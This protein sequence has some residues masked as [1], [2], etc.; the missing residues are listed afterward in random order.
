[1]HGCSSGL[2]TQIQSPPPPPKCS[3]THGMATRI[4]QGMSTTLSNSSLCLSLF[5]Q[6]STAVL[7]CTC[8]DRLGESH[9]KFELTRNI[10]SLH[11]RH[12]HLASGD[13]ALREQKSRLTQLKIH[14]ST[15]IWKVEMHRRGHVCCH[16]SRTCDVLLYGAFICLKVTLPP[17]SFLHKLFNTEWTQW[18][19]LYSIILPL[20][21]QYS[22]SSITIITTM[23]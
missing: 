13:F 8:P 6:C 23:L 11:R 19:Q 18:M 14:S 20:F 4:L 5:S 22:P 21:S 10:N 1:M 3:L 12:I 2:H 16:E 17:T 15:V 7:L 9:S